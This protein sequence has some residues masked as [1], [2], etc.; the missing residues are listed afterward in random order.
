M[1]TI[2]AGDAVALVV[3]LIILID[4][5]KFRLLAET[6]QDRSFKSFTCIALLTIATGALYKYSSSYT[7]ILITTYAV[8]IL[9]TLT[10][11]LVWIVKLVHGQTPLVGR[12][13]KTMITIFGLGSI[14]LF[15]N[16]FAGSLIPFFQMKVLFA[17]IV[18]IFLLPAIVTVWKGG[19]ELTVFVRNA[20][21]SIPVIVLIGV[22]VFLVRGEMLGITVSFVIATLF[23]YLLIQ[24]YRYSIDHLTGALNRRALMSRVSRIFSG[25]TQGSILVLDIANFSYF[26]QN[27]GQQRGDKLLADIAQF[28][29]TVSPE[30]KVYRYSGDQFAIV[31][32]STHRQQMKSVET[33]IFGRFSSSWEIDDIRAKI[34]VR[35]A[36]VPFPARFMNTEAFV[37]AMDLTLHHAK[38]GDSNQVSVYTEQ[39]RVDHERRI[40]VQ[41]A[42]E[43]AIE[44][45]TLKV[46][47]QPIYETHSLNIY[48]AEALSRIDDPYIGM[49]SP[50]EFIPIAE[51]TGLIVELTYA[52][53][54]QVCK[55]WLDIG[56]RAENLK[57]IAVN[58]SAVN[59]LEPSMEEHI[60]DMLH[61][62]GIPPSKVKFE[63]T[64]TTIIH[65]FDQVK[66]VMDVCTAAG[67]SFSLD[68]YGKGYSNLEYL[69]N[70]P[71]STVKI[72]K[73]IVQACQ[74]NYT[75]IESIIL[76]LTRMGKKVVAEGIETEQQLDLLSRAGATRLQGFLFSRP[77]TAEAL[78]QLVV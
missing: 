45:D 50:A 54:R 43:R 12:L 47:Y 28:L 59:F 71:F 37:S 77:M 16:L 9:G 2:L 56:D 62:Y 27:F 30:Q 4:A 40:K 14:F 1:L 21:L 41:E 42:I 23:S 69:V 18:L 34:S 26:N 20:L 78:E 32:T 72:D 64:E 29:Y 58:L 11:A 61:S 25:S 51:E 63:I 33:K 35:M 60:L 19:R 24:N 36:E 76:M 70:L 10:F 31:F 39:I 46:V 53:L 52:V 65:S 57:R 22:A 49:L 3:I 67:M 7:L 68:D 8:G 74:K 15:A 44:R 38:M 6:S 5:T 66:R 55:L 73:S 75:L 13:S 17:C 48:S